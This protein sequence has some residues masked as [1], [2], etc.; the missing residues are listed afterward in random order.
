MGPR[1][2]FIDR[3]K[4]TQAFRIIEAIVRNPYFSGRQDSSEAVLRDSPI[5]WTFTSGRR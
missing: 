4:T 2:G 3:E 1:F 5:Q